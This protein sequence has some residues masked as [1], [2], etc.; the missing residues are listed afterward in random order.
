MRHPVTSRVQLAPS[1][2][3][4]CVEVSAAE[5]GEEKLKQARMEYPPLSQRDSRGYYPEEEYP[6]TF[7]Q[8][9]AEYPPVQPDYYPHLPHRAQRGDA[10]ET[11]VDPLDLA[12]SHVPFAHDKRRTRTH[13]LTVPGP[14]QPPSLISRP[15]LTSTT[16]HSTGRQNP[17]SIQTPTSL[18]PTPL[19][20][21]GTG[22]VPRQQQQPTPPLRRSRHLH[23]H[24]S[25][26]PVTTD[27]RPNLPPLG[28]PSPLHLLAPQP[29]LLPRIRT[30]G[31]RPTRIQRHA[32]QPPPQRRAPPHARARIRHKQSAIKRF[33]T[34][35]RKTSSGRVNAKGNLVTQGPKNR[36]GRD[37]G[38]DPPP[39]ANKPA[40]FVLYI[41]SV[42]TLLL[43][44]YLFIFRPCCCSPRK[45]GKD[46]GNPLLGNG[47]MVLPVPGGGGEG[48]KKGGGGGKRG[49]KGGKVKGGGG[50]DVRVNLIVD[51]HAFNVQS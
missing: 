43:L 31:L 7:P 16:T 51:P 38:G 2:R 11:S 9:E 22:T 29:S 10:S 24:S 34:Q 41:L 45:K 28:P 3:S 39:P 23:T 50:G 35:E 25:I 8:A 42:F 15:T 47:M 5:N 13:R 4:L 40:A 33:L 18:R 14:S 30:M 12:D 48:K 44:L 21:L 26:P 36:F 19:P 20:G 17:C 37:G 6:H 27:V 1:D 49:K 32:T 46:V